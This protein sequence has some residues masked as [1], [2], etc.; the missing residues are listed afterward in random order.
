MILNLVEGDHMTPEMHAA[1]GGRPLTTARRAIASVAA[2]MPGA[3]TVGELTAAVRAGDARS[4]ANATVYR[5]VTAMEAAGFLERVGERDGSALYAR[6]AHGTHHHHV[7][8]DGCGRVAHA[9]CPLGE[10]ALAS[11]R[12]AGFTVTRHELTLY[13][14]CPECA[15]KDL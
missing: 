9:D 13:G 15:E 8:C 4:G 1:Y 5:A 2:S 7:V 10:A 6:C 11:A 14:L 12:D 3:F